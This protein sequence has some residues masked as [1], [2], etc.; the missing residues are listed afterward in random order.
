MHLN[1][2]LDLTGLHL[3]QMISERIDAQM[4]NA[5]AYVKRFR[6]LEAHV[7]LTITKGIDCMDMEKMMTS[8]G[9]WLQTKKNVLGMNILK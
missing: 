3:E 2:I 8:T 7:N 9:N 1:A 6:R 5:I 4:E